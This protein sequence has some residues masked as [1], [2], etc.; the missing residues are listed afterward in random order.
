MSQRSLWNLREKD[1]LTSTLEMHVGLEVFIMQSSLTE[2][3]E[4]DPCAS[5]RDN[6]VLSN[7]LGLECTKGL[8]LVPSSYDWKSSKILRVDRPSLPLLM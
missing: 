1:A 4:R 5:F 3:Y 8:M 2:N 7:V 6:R